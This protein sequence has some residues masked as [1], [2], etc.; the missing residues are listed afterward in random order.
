VAFGHVSNVTGLM[1]PAPEIVAVAKK[2]GLLTLVDAAQSVPHMKLNVKKLGCDFLAF[3]GHKMTG[4]SGTGALYVRRE[5]LSKARPVE[6]GGGMATEV[7]GSHYQLEGIPNRF[8]AGTPNIEG[9]IGL[10]A[11]I[12]FLESIGMDAIHQHSLKLGRKLVKGLQSVAD[13]EVYPECVHDH[14]GI[15]SFVLPGIPAD[16]LARA[17]SDD[18]GIMTRSGFHCAEPLVR[19][20]GHPGIVRVSLYLYNT[21]EEIGYII[22]ALKQIRQELAVSRVSS[23]SASR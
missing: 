17:L 16:E 7:S 13:L 2:H 9:T 19:H 22:R 11:T 15:A 1:N 4:P 5:L 14:I 12:D 10:G 6:F 21:F 8:E 20:F 23:R 18:F 3:S